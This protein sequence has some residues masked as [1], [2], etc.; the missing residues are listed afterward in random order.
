MDSMRTEQEAAETQ[1]AAAALWADSSLSPEQREAKLTDL[2]LPYAGKS[3]PP[4]LGEWGGVE[5][6]GRTDEAEPPAPAHS[7]VSVSVSVSEGVFGGARPEGPTDAEPKFDPAT[8]GPDADPRDA[9]IHEE[10]RREWG[11]KY[12][13]R[14]HEA[15]AELRNLF[16]GQVEVLD[17]L[18]K[19]IRANYGPK[20]EAMAV[21][22]LA[23]LARLRRS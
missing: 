14:M 16:D 6:G 3:S 17:D 18:G 22:F 5:I 8:Y 7:P 15:A 23:D 12:D 13:A 4:R 21:Q 20:G 2:Y 10:L 1:K 19:R 9:F 11:A